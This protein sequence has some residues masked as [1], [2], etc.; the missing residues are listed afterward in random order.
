MAVLGVYVSLK[1]QRPER[2]T[3]FIVAFILLCLGGVVVNV[4]QTRL[5]SKAQEDLKAELKQIKKNTE[6]PPTVNVST[7]AP[8]ITVAVSKP[9]AFVDFDHL[10]LN[11]DQK[12][13]KL[14]VNAIVISKLP[15]PARNVNARFSAALMPTQNG[16][17]SRQTQ[18]KCF[19]EFVR[20]P[21][22]DPAFRGALGLGQQIFGTMIVTDFNQP[23][24]DKI[25]SGEIALMAVGRIS[26]SDDNGSH[27]KDFC[28]WV[29][30]PLFTTAAPTTVVTHFCESHND[31]QY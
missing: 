19:S 30:P 15:E 16:V 9:K 10:Q 12:E 27:G 2:H 31:L 11:W 14:T 13:S 23:M 1:P 22:G 17:P 3:R 6:T 7:P 28:Q 25:N 4:I 26:F 20:L 24:V 18:D 29:Q 21:K 5:A 8:Q